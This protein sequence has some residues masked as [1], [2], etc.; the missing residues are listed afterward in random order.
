MAAL[1][2]HAVSG[3]CD[4][5]TSAI[6]VPLL[7]STRLCLW[8]LASASRILR[9]AAV[10]PAHLAATCTLLINVLGFSPG[11][12]KVVAFLIFASWEVPMFTLTCVLCE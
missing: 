4:R 10:T 3:T 12:L 7:A 1:E 8:L 6:L 5:L 2:S 9:G 11:L